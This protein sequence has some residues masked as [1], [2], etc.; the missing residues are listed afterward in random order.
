MDKSRT[1]Q[2]E[3]GKVYQNR[4]GV[5]Y[6][7]RNSWSTDALVQSMGSGWTCIAHE[8]QIYADGTIE[9]NWS[10]QLGFEPL[11]QEQKQGKGEQKR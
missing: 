1:V 10:T 9:W 11:P 7:C 5:R 4:N 8:V 3:P 2:L 6:L